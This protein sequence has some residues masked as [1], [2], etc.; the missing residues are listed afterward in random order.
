[1][2]DFLFPMYDILVNTIFGSIG[3]SL[4]VIGGVI[5]MILALCRT[6]W[7]FI[8][9]WLMF[10]VMVAVSLYLG[11]LGLVISFILVT[12]YFTVQIIRLAYPDR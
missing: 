6:S 2:A 9:Y 7:V 10:Y 5:T 8:L 3:L 4:L 1:M 11:A 12:L